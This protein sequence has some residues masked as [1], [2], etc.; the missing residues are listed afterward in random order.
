MCLCIGAW[1][2]EWNLLE[3][4]EETLQH[5]E[6]VYFPWSSATWD[7]EAF[8]RAFWFISTITSKKL[9]LGS[10]WFG[11]GRCGQ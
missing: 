10:A 3:Q 7:L 5:D 6:D 9:G 11:V 1:C 2:C 8:Q 4:L